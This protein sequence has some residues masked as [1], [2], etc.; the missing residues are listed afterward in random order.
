MTDDDEEAKAVMEGLAGVRACIVCGRRLIYTAIQPPD[1]QAARLLTEQGIRLTISQ[2]F[3]KFC[4]IDCLLNYDEQAQAV[5]DGLAG[6]RRCE[7]GEL[8]ILSR[9]RCDD[10]V[11]KR[12][13]AFEDK[14]VRFL[15]D[16]D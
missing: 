15:T 14:L 7:C 16:N 3:R 9:H 13:Q 10:C 11:R 2:P 12:M 4:C 5:Q 8:I 6:V 1:T